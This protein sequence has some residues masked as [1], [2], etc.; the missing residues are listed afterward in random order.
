M[1][2]AAGVSDP[3]M[4]K[5]TPKALRRSISLSL[6]IFARALGFVGVCGCGDWPP[7]AETKAQIDSLPVTTVSIRAR[8]LKDADTPALAKL[9]KLKN[10]DFAGGMA[11]EKAAI[12][13]AGIA[14]LAK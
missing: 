13:D 6:R 3:K 14:A 10:L 5:L 2:K 8:G 4:G 1:H 11:V 9:R 7:I 12:T